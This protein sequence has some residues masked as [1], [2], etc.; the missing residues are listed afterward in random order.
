MPFND[1]FGASAISGS[2]MSAERFRMEV[3]AN[4]IA[5]AN[6][7]RSAN[8]GPYRRQDVVFAEVLGDALRPGNEPDLRG[9][10][11]VDVV[12]DQGEFNR[13]FMPGHPD[14][15]AQ[16][17][18]LLPNV[19]LPIEMVNLLTATRAYE[20]NLKTA[21]TFRTMSEQALSLLRG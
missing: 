20:A 2:G 8:G 3:I 21:Q 17:F 13:V 7:T 12:E 14:A 15:D 1:L 10:R 6:S 5:N 11:A 9:V 16:G 4:N 18:V 19:Q